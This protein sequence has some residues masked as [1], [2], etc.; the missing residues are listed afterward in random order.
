MSQLLVNYPIMSGGA[1][2]I[3]ETDGIDWYRLKLL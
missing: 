2:A 1:S 3:E